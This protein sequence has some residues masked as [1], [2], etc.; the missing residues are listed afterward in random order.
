M[1]RF[2]QK[3]P[4]SSRVEDFGHLFCALCIMTTIATCI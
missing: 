1:K 2:L 3:N 4:T